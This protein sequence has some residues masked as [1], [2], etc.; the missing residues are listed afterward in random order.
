M[1]IIY[2]QTPCDNKNE[3][4]ECPL[5]SI[6]YH[7]TKYHSFKMVIKVK[8]VAPVNNV[9]TL[10]IITDV[11]QF[12]SGHEVLSLHG[13]YKLKIHEETKHLFNTTD[14]QQCGALCPP[15]EFGGCQGQS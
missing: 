13:Y 10:I 7:Q 8:G 11:T 4:R 14:K 3:W 12:L 5:L 15:S 9:S 1:P 6:D 2:I